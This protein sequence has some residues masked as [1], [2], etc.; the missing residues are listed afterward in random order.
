MDS[1]L[2]RHI[3]KSAAWM[4]GSRVT[5][6]AIGLLSTTILAR[7]LRPEDFGLVALAM[8]VVGAMEI[9][10]EFSFDVALIRDGRAVREHYD[11]V[12]TLSL[13]RGIV[14][15][16]VLIALAWPA[17]TF[18]GDPRIELIVYCFAATA[19]FEGLQNVG[20]I[21]FRK[22]LNF[23]RE[24]AFQAIAKLITF[25]TTLT[26]AIVW[27]QYWALVIGIMVGKA[28]NVILSYA[29]HSYRP[30]LSLGEWRSLVGFSKWLLA[31]N[32]GNFLS[33]RL[34]TFAIGRIAGA[35][36]VGLYEVANEISNLPKGELIWPIQRAL[37]PGYAKLMGDR[38]HLASG[39]LD[40]LGAI[41][42][43]A[44]PAAVGIAC[45]APLIVS[46]FLGPQW[47]DALPLL[48]VLA[49]AGIISVG[50]ANAQTVLLTLGRA[51]LLSYLSAVNLAIFAPFVVTGTIVWGP[52]GAA[53]A[54]VATSAIMLAIYVV[55]TLQ[56]LSLQFRSIVVVVWRS[57]A[58]AFLMACALY[59][60]IVSWP[61]GDGDGA[62][63]AQLAA[64]IGVGA[65]VYIGTHLAL[66]RM[67]GSP[68]GT[69]KNVLFILVSYLE[70]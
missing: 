38:D 47:L 69:E 61:L 1:E 30:R 31:A 42:I 49:I 35:S 13:I 64:S 9:F 21:D 52:I 66:W 32:I 56:A 41:M 50:Y 57:L 63:V 15:G 10:G 8:A 5:V 34:D 39:Y 26:F 7:L 45:I 70:R 59:F 16:G 67:V 4:V 40:G 48:Q 29:M 19:L 62:P 65:L 12:W 28:A 33:E 51:K 6:R 22:E 11:T 58:A 44:I 55:I 27:R 60:L 17:A 23:H 3:A 68:A 36:A 43:M 20:I 37:F 24:F 25:V 18:F 14:V 54:V 2:G 53:V 46:V